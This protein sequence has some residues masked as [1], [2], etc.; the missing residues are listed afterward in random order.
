[1]HA[2]ILKFTL[3]PYKM[4]LGPLCQ[5]QWIGLAEQHK[6]LDSYLKIITESDGE[7][8]KI[9]QHPL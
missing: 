8:K 5:K 9:R 3:E 4:I 2:G 6:N 7:I 1:M